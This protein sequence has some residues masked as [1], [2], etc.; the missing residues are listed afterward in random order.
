MIPKRRLALIA[1]LAS[2]LS[3][4]LTLKIRNVILESHK[5]SKSSKPVCAEVFGEGESVVLP[6]KKQTVVMH[7][8]T[9]SGLGNR[10]ID[11]LFSME[12]ARKHNLIY[13]FNRNGFISNP[14]DA[15]HTWLAD[16]ITERYGDTRL[17]THRLFHVGDY[18]KPLPALTP[19]E[20]ALHDGYFMDGATACAA[21]DCF[22][23][24][25]SDF[26]AGLYT[27]NNEFQNL[28]GVTDKNREGR[29]AIHI[30]LGDL[31]HLL[32]P[33]QYL[34]IVEGLQ[35]KYLSGLDGPRLM[36][37]VHF[38]YHIPT[39]ENRYEYAPEKEVKTQATL[40]FL[41]IAFPK[42]EFHDFHTLEKSVRFMAYSEFLITS[43][44]S[45]SYMAGY[46]CNGC[47]VVFTTPKEWIRTKVTMTQENYKKS[48]YYMDGWD[49]DLAFY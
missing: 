21:S 11:L 32:E 44:S 49:P 8:F 46:F 7:E 1:I 29:V 35:K 40:D 39:E 37:N 3:L 6:V 10:F 14:R 23:L 16:M 24:R 45:L 17:I 31:T 26:A 41:K 20:K 30:R 38:V 15:D 48:L 2:A 25:V 5:E 4:F 36:D 18:T 33:E 9:W 27:R 42:A 43:G 28:L 34:K 22:E 13:S 19:G 12:Y 47:H